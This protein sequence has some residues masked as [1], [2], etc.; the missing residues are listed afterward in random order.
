MICA[1]GAP[2]ARCLSVWS[3]AKHYRAFRSWRLPLSTVV[4]LISNLICTHTHR[5]FILNQATH[6]LTGKKEMCSNVVALTN[7]DFYTFTTMVYSSSVY[8]DFVSLMCVISMQL[9]S[10]LI[11][12]SHSSRIALMCLV[13]ISRRTALVGI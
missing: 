8:M 12:V 4:N 2:Y 3:R 10:P 9:S 13:S 11:P 1:I 6:L 7:Y 5:Y